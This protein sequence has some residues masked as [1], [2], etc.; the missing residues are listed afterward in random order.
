MCTGKVGKMVNQINQ[1]FANMQQSFS[2]DNDISIVTNIGTGC[3][4]VDNAFG[5]GTLCAIGVNMSHHI[6]AQFLFLFRSQLI[7]DVGDVCF[8]L[9]NLLLGNIKTQF[10]LSFGQGHP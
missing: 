3:A 7:I 4:E 1:L 10:T 6:M 5:F 8:E 2:V 9:S